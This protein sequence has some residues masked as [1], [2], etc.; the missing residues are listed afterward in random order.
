MENNLP[1]KFS[2]LLHLY[3]PFNQYTNILEKIAH[4]SYLPMT[5]GLKS[6]PNAQ[7]TMNISGGLLQ[8]LEKNGHTKFID[9]VGELLES[10]K[11]ELLGSSA[12]HAFLPLI[13]VSEIKRQL[14][15]NT[16]ILQSY[17]GDLYKPKGFFP[18]EMAVTEDLLKIVSREGFEYSVVPSL[19]S[20]AYEGPFNSYYLNDTNLELVFR[21]KPLSQLILSHT[22]NDAEDFLYEATDFTNEEFWVFIV[23]G[24]TFGHHH[25]GYEKFLFDLMNYDKLKP[26][27]IGDLTS[28]VTPDLPKKEVSIRP[29]TWSNKEQ[30]FFLNKEQD[31]THS[32]ILWK[33]GENPI[34]DLQWEFFDFVVS[35]VENFPEKSTKSWKDARNMLD[36]AIAS[37]QFWWASAK[38][39]WSF[40]MIELGAHTL[41]SVILL[42]D[43]SEEI[44]Q[45]ALS[46]YA[47][48]LELVFSS[49]RSG[50]IRS[51]L[52]HHDVDTLK[53]TPLKDRTHNEWY[54]QIILE[55]EDQ[56]LKDAKSRNYDKALRWRKAL[57]KIKNGLDIYDAL[58]DIDFLWT[59]RT[60]PSLKPFFEYEY[61]EF[62]DFAKEH[63]LGFKGKEEFE[64]WKQDKTKRYTKT[65]NPKAGA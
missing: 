36:Y 22:T 42:L 49:H 24:E 21:N 14:E 26:M 23:D 48:L 34:H 51:V 62:S 35:T 28:T 33:D 17:F 30:D 31:P 8:L 63:F 57:Y 43:C 16:K 46:Y 19:S 55:L 4:E 15:L 41:K 32:F 27:T 7:V 58:H 61:E 64:K 9:N 45:K 10:G 1:M 3:Q 6:L 25:I 37:D 20:L 47:E 18:V 5:E 38:P 40:E 12:Y 39:W 56:M 11:V 60:L 29:C 13:P 52:S 50:Y 44:K 2:I 59:V 53:S 65:Y 54:N